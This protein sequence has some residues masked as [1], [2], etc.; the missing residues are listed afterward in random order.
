[1]LVG[2]SD[3][4]VL[5]FRF[6]G[7]ILPFTSMKNCSLAAAISTIDRNAL[8]RTIDRSTLSRTSDRSTLSRTIDRSTLSRTSDRSTLSRSSLLLYINLSNSFFYSLSLYLFLSLILLQDSSCSY[9]HLICYIALY[10]FVHF[11]F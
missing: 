8:S 2:M 1:M 5:A 6:T 3:R 10:L 7:N 11:P 9:L 4:R